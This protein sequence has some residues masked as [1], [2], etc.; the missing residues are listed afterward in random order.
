MCL[1]QERVGGFRAFIYREE[2]PKLGVQAQTQVSRGADQE[3]GCQGAHV[4]PRLVAPEMAR[5]RLILGHI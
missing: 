1:S 4:G 5:A 2:R 3:L